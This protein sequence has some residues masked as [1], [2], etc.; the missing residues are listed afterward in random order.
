MAVS[1]QN[2]SHFEMQVTPGATIG[3]VTVLEAT[4]PGGLQPGTWKYVVA[5][6]DSELGVTLARQ[7]LEFTIAE[8]GAMTTK[9]KNRTKHV[10]PHRVLLP[11]SFPG[12]GK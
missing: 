10:S 4:I 2:T 8:P 3:P 12:L 1:F 11:R 5:I 6:L 9:L 7:C